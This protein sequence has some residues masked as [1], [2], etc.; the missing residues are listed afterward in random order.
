MARPAPPAV[1]DAR[2]PLVVAI[3]GNIGAGKSLLCTGLKV[4][5]GDAVHVHEE[6]IDEW[7][8]LL[9][10]FYAKPVERAFAFQCAL[11]ASH[12]RTSAKLSGQQRQRDGVRVIVTERS[13]YGNEAFLRVQ[14]RLGNISD[15]QRDVYMALRDAARAITDGHPDVLVHLRCASVDTY[16]QRIA[17]RGRE[18]ESGIPLSYL[19]LLEGEHDVLLPERA[20]E[21]ALAYVRADADLSVADVVA[22]VAR[23]IETAL[24]RPGAVHG[25]PPLLAPM[26][27]YV[28]AS[29]DMLGALAQG[30]IVCAP[31]GLEEAANA[32]SAFERAALRVVS[33]MKAVTQTHAVAK[34]RGVRCMCTYSIMHAFVDVKRHEDALLSDFE[35]LAL[36]CMHRWLLP[37]MREMLVP[38]Y[39]DRGGNDET[40]R[41]VEMYLPLWQELCTVLV[42]RDALPAM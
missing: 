16:A 4:L 25:A 22:Q 23:H 38:V 33:A 5:L 8:A 39:T 17:Y 35:R 1:G 20:S 37:L 31:S 6:P 18:A 28:G 3:E 11:L 19:R 42:K 41:I 7:S 24:R 34:G 12:A 29:A 36:A 10:G 40:R 15:A 2:R 14:H 21:H 13:I 32:R 30:A 27:S 9:K 26:L